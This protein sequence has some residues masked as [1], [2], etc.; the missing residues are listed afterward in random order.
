[1]PVPFDIQKDHPFLINHCLDHLNQDGIILFSN[2]FQK[3]KL[4]AD[5]LDTNNIQD[6]TKETIPEDFKNDKIHKCY[7]IK[8]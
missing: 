8:H 3:F 6:I 5:A 7:I 4:N 2:N 1:M